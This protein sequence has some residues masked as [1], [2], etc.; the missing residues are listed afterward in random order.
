MVA[1][2][3]AEHGQDGTRLHREIRQQGFRGCVAT[4][5]GYVRKRRGQIPEVIQKLRLLPDFPLPSPRQAAW[6]LCLDRD[7]LEQLER[8]YVEALTRLSPEI[9]KMQELTKEF[10][11]IAK[12]RQEPVLDQWPEGLGKADSMNCKA[13]LMG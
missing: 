10:Q 2:R 12:Q 8:E 9:K 6:W 11:Q 5:L 1:F 3:R 13:L 4:V 7:R